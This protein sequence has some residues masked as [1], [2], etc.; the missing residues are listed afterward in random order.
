MLSIFVKCETIS[1][2]I[3]VELFI[4]KIYHIQFYFVFHSFHPNIQNYKLNIIL[5]LM[6]IF[7]FDLFRIFLHSF[8]ISYITSFR[9]FMKMKILLN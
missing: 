3:V 1:F 6:W 5:I 2:I 9:K 8:H 4:S 7:I